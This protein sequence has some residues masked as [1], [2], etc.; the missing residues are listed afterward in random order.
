[1]SP[2]NKGAPGV[3]IAI[4]G[5]GAVGGHIAARL[6]HAETPVSIVARN[7]HLAAIRQRGLTLIAGADRF[8][9]HPVATDRPADLG[10]QD[11]VV[12]TV[13]APGLPAA[14]D[15]M[16]PLI[17]NDTRVVFAMNGLPW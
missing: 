6:A 17:R 5:A 16:A 15:A 10:P 3:K 11:I 4:F 13:K 8:T 1:M 9:V 12:V 14:M 7:A 2:I